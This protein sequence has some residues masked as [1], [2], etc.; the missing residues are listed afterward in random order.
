[1]E[2]IGLRDQGRMSRLPNPI[3]VDPMGLRQVTLPGDSKALPNPA[4]IL[5]RT[6]DEVQLPEVGKS[7]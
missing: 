4:L 7:C 2:G 6:W 1:M 5:S 3:L